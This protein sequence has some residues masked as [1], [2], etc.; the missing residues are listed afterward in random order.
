MNF[1]HKLILKFVLKEHSDLLFL[2]S[3][4]KKFDIN[5]R[6]MKSWL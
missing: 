1:Q 5:G 2:F 4:P 6:D 3:F